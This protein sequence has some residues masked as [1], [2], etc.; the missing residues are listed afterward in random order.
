MFV[1]GGTV[2]QSSG[3]IWGEAFRE[4]GL[5]DDGA[6][7]VLEDGWMRK[8]EDRC[9]ARGGCRLRYKEARYT[10]HSTFECVLTGFKGYPSRG[11]C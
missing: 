6:A 9:C 4:A 3:K 5:Q 7:R 1:A 10:E 2:A 11:A 8:R